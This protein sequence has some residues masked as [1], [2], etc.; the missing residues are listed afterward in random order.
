M[1][2]RRG[3]GREEI[4]PNNFE[5]QR[6]IQTLQTAYRIV[7]P[8]AAAFLC[9]SLSLSL[10]IMQSAKPPR[11]KPP[12]WSTESHLTVFVR[13][14]RLLQ[15]DQREDWPNINLRTL[16]ASS[17]NQRQRV[18]AVEWALYQLFVIWDPDGAQDVCFRDCV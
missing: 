15:L 18:K 2:R 4:Q 13:N 6:R 12:N 14:L 8:P 5:I 11:P 3:D 9:P 7:Y 17:Q 1:E 16:S 10:S